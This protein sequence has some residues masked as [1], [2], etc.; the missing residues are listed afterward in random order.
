MQKNKNKILVMDIA[1]MI[2]EFY[3]TLQPKNFCLLC[4]VLVV[5]ML[6]FFSQ[7][8]VIMLR[9]A[10]L[11]QKICHLQYYH[12]LSL[13][14]YYYY[15]FLSQYFVIMLR[16]HEGA[17]IAALSK[18]LQLPLGSLE[19]SYGHGRSGIFYLGHWHEGC[20]FRN[21]LQRGH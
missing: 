15:Y 8:F 20:G 2:D 5:I 4:T 19:A 3:T 17:V 14:F 9:N 6:F 18:H 13:C 10:E 16:N 11:I 1:M 12:Q 7:Y 21:R